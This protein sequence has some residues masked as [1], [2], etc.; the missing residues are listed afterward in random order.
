MHMSAQ[1]PEYTHRVSDNRSS[2]RSNFS[3]CPREAQ[4]SHELQSTEQFRTL[5][6]SNPGHPTC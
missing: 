5:R 4:V 1:L 2:Q 3:N 6:D